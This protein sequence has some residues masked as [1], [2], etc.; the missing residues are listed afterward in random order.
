MKIEASFD[1]GCKED[2]RLAELLIKYDIPA[3]FYIPS[4]WTYVN[5]REGREPLSFN[6]LQA[7]SDEF[8]IGSH[9]ITHPLLTRIRFNL[10]KEEIIESK[11]ELEEMLGVSVTSFCYP[12]GYANDQIR[13]VVRKHYKTAR[14]TLVGNIQEAKDPIWQTTSVHIAGKRRKEYE[15]TTWQQEARM[16]LLRASRRKDGVF[17]MWGHSWEISRYDAWD[18]FEKFLKELHEYLPSKV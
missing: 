1:D 9:T 15:F 5:Q 16:W 18:E 6:D 2:L 14:N 10:A 3:T 7:L 11:I 17:H 12:R 13:D 4:D 8:E